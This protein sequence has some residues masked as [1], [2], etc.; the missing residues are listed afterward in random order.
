MFPHEIYFDTLFP[1]NLKGE[2][3]N[4]VVTDQDSTPNRV[5]QKNLPWSV[6]VNWHIDGNG[7]TSLAGEWR[8]QLKLESMGDG[9]EGT[10]PGA[11]ITKTL[12]DVEPGMSTVTHRHWKHVFNNL[13]T[14]FLDPPL[15]N[16]VEEGVF[17][18]ILIITYKDQF[19][20]PL[21]MAGSL[22]GPLLT[23]YKT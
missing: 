4:I 17:R 9:F 2:V 12:A 18:L 23:F 16:G 13:G 20:T 3:R 10:I 1:A 5:L 14:T 19:A 7:A 11:D 21:A 22:E 6:E 8:V 15:N